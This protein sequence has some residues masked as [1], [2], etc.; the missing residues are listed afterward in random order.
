MIPDPNLVVEALRYYADLGLF[1]H[2]A[3]TAFI[4]LPHAETIAEMWP[5]L[6]ARPVALQELAKL[7]GREPR[8][9]ELIA[10]ARELLS[11]CYVGSTSGAEI[12]TAWTRRKV[13]AIT[14]L[15]DALKNLEAV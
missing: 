4:A 3:D 14:S 11:Q 15:R 6:T 8:V 10:A 13:R 12:E 5:A 9:Q 2:G 7:Q 1:G